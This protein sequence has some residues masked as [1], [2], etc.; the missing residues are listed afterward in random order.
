[1][2]LATL[3]EAKTHTNHL[4]DLG[5]PNTLIILGRSADA[6]GKNK[7]LIFTMKATS[8]LPIGLLYILELLRHWQI[9]RS[10]WHMSRLHRPQQGRIFRIAHPVWITKP[11]LPYFALNRV[12]YLAAS[13][14]CSCNGS[15]LRLLPHP[16][17]YGC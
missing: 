4:N 8:R 6:L 5:H 10:A 3:C 17:L 12:Y 11:A 7:K 15:V 2:R 16:L 1:M 9:H 14:L 13:K